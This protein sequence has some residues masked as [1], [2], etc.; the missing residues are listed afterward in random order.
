MLVLKT[1]Y[2]LIIILSHIVETASGFLT[3]MFK[4][5]NKKQPEE[6]ATAVR[7]AV[8]QSCCKLQLLHFQSFNNFKPSSVSTI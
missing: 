5:I 1:D 8:R 4:C 2:F 6:T 3:D 7:R